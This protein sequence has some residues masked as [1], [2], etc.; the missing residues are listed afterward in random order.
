MK[1]ADLQKIAAT[2]TCAK[3]V[4]KTISWDIEN[5]NGEK[6]TQSGVIS[7]LV[8]GSRSWGEAKKVTERHKEAGGAGDAF[9]ISEL[10]KLQDGNVPIDVV[11]SLPESMVSAMLA[12]IVEV[13]PKLAVKPAQG[14]GEQ[15][16]D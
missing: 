6:E 11:D 2:S 10:I 7:V 14:E 8:V 9:L 4:D 13:N 5:E 12:A 15:G 1:L 16:N 3:Y